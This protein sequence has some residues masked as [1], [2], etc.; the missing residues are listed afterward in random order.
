MVTG[1]YNDCCRYAHV[2]RDTLSS[3]GM[4]CARA[5]DVER[6]RV[7]IDTIDN[8]FSDDEED[9]EVSETKASLA[10]PTVEVYNCD[11]VTC[12][13]VSLLL[14]ASAVKEGWEH[15]RVTVQVNLKYSDICLYLFLI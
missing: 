3:S 15:V 10:V 9:E 12:R 13:S 4:A 5:I 14:T 11:C 1:A 6:A 8:G 2:H 7:A